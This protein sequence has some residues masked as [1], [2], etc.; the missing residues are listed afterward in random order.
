MD[1]KD[2]ASE[3][4]EGSEEHHR[5]N[6]H[7]LQE[8]VCSATQSCPTLWGPL[9]WNPPD[10]SVLK[11]DFQGKDTGMGCYFLFQ[12][13]SPTQGSN[14]R[15]LPLLRWQTDSLPLRHLGSLNLFQEQL[16]HH[17]QTVSRSMDTEGTAP[18]KEVR[19]K[20]L[21]GDASYILEDDEQNCVL[22]VHGKQN[23]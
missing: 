18:Q 21:K 5:G 10:S 11:W 6:L 12:E 9:R 23:L 14:S 16:N 8:C 15:L 17:E 4:S 22:H 1:S 13:I 19:N 3:G 20:L 2:S 7:P